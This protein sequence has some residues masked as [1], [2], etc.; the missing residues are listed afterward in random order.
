MGRV[1]VSQLCS[2]RCSRSNFEAVHVQDMC[3]AVSVCSF[4]LHAVQ[5][6]YTRPS[7]QRCQEHVSVL[8][9][10]V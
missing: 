9:L 4:C 2:T 3:A 1:H 8:P 6:C 5:R 10:V 7:M